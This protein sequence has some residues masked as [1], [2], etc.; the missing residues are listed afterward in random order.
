MKPKKDKISWVSLG[1]ERSLKSWTWSMV[2]AF[3]VWVRQKPRKATAWKQSWAL[4]GETQYPLQARKLRR[5]LFP[6]QN[7]AE[8]G[9]TGGCHRHIVEVYW[10]RNQMLGQHRWK[11]QLRV[12]WQ[13]KQ[14]LLRAR[15]LARF[16]VPKEQGQRSRAWEMAAQ[17]L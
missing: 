3:E 1:E 15:S 8:R 10:V 16:T 5:L 14:A 13:S 6:F 2:S 4:A 9:S 11:G 12:E 7:P 17:F